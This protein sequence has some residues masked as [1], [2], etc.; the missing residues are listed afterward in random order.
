MARM[1][2]CAVAAALVAALA[3]RALDL[4]PLFGS[5]HAD[6]F[7]IYVGS[8]VALSTVWDVVARWLERR[9]KR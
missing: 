9:R 2:A 3:C 4:P 1:L 7:V 6:G 8:Y 5:L